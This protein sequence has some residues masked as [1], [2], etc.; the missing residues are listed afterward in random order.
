MITIELGPRPRGILL[1]EYKRQ[2]GTKAPPMLFIGAIMLLSGAAWNA[3]FAAT[4]VSQI[5]LGAAADW[6]C[7]YPTSNLPPTNEISVPFTRSAGDVGTELKC[8]LIAADVGADAPKNYTVAS[9]SSTKESAGRFHFA[10]PKS[11][12]PGQYH[13]D[14]TEDG[15]PLKSITFTIATPATGN[16]PKAGELVGLDKIK[17]WTYSDVMEAAPGIQLDVPPGATKGSDGKIR[18][19]LTYAQTESGPDGTV[20]D[21]RHG[22]QPTSR[23]WWKIGPDEFDITKREVGGHSFAMEPPELD[24]KSPSNHMLQWNSQSK[25]EPNLTFQLWGPVSLKSPKG[26]VSGYVV[27]IDQPGDPIHTTLERDYIPGVGMVREVMTS[28]ANGTMIAREEKILTAY[29]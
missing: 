14:V 23:E 4:E 11:F 26:D 7:V 6:T 27:F 18:A 10:L 28:A 8:I 22:G 19:V 1:W 29:K 3:A 5:C 20:I 15:R 25:G 9:V 2:R 12:P 16:L 17:T 21:I 24:L 13:A